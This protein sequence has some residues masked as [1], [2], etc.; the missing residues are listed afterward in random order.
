MIGHDDKGVQ[1]E[2]ALR[3]VVLKDFEHEIGGSLNLKEPAAIG[4]NRGDEKRADF[5]RG[6]VH[7]SR[8]QGP[9]LKPLYF[10]G[11]AIQRPKDRCS[12]HWRTRAEAL[13]V[14]TPGMG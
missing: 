4:R 11:E 14:A 2:T 8:I 13:I 3:T 10:W 6:V 5:L 12:L 7:R 1:G 9:R